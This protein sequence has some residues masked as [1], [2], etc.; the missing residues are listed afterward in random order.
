MKYK[1][2]GPCLTGASLRVYHAEEDKD[3]SVENSKEAHYL[4]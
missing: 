4:I 2:M 3:F 1:Y